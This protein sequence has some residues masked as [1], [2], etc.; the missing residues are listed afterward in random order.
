MLQYIVQP[1]DTL[2]FIA[3]KFNTSTDI[4]VEANNLNHRNDIYPGQ[5]IYIP[6]FSQNSGINSNFPTLRRGA[7]GP[8]VF[9]I[10]SQLAGLG[11]YVGAMDGIFQNITEGSVIQFQSSRDL[12]PT[13]IVD[14]VTWQQLFKDWR[15]TT[16]AP[17]FQAKMVLPGL[18]MILSL[19]KRS[20]KPRESVSITLLKVNLTSQTIV[21]NYNTGQRYDFKITYPS[22]KILWRW[23]EGKSFVQALG[24]VN[25]IPNQCIH[26]T[27][28]FQFPP[29][30]NAGVYQVCGWN[31]ARQVEHLKL[32]VQIILEPSG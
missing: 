12:P 4:I 14:K 7:Q 11:Y 26:Y 32:S 21:L 3:L 10:Q 19:D 1:G 13:G 6:L 8:F 15:A 20:Y 30:E 9:L 23:S 18:L 25:L 29:S 31:V 22:G 5:V 2:Y 17:P 27:E 28:N 16:T 24:S